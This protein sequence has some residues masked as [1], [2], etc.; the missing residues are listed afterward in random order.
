MSVF[1]TKQT[2]N[3]VDAT[4]AFDD[5]LTVGGTL[6]A[7]GGQT[8]GPDGVNATWVEDALDAD[9]QTLSV[10]LDGGDGAVYMWEAF[11][12]YNAANQTITALLSG[13]SADMESC[14][15]GMFQANAAVD[16]GAPF[17]GAGVAPATGEVMNNVG[18][19]T[20]AIGRVKRGV[21]SQRAGEGVYITCDLDEADGITRARG[22]RHIRRTTAGEV[23][24]FGL[25]ATGATGM[26]AGSWL[27]VRR[28][29]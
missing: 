28:V 25:T 11:I 3:D 7:P 2:S 5:N 13:S 21:I 20:A 14:V 19:T 15:Y 16:S 9:G 1:G 26:L 8:L 23:T 4:S 24:S 6:H 22:T 29:S 17:T 12:D 27:R 18:G 10:D